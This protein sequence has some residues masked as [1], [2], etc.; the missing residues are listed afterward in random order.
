MLSARGYKVHGTQTV[1]LSWSGATSG[2][3]DIF[4]NGVLIVT[5]ANDGFYTDSIGV[6]GHATYTYQVCN[7]GTNT[8]SNQA[9]VT[10]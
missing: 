6:K 3:V 10:F 1:D 9:T 4:R 7:A 5:T 8:C 2:N